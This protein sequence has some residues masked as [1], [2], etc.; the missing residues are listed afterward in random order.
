MICSKDTL[1]IHIYRDLLSFILCIVLAALFSDKD[2]VF[3]I[4]TI[5]DLDLRHLR[6]ASISTT[7]IRVSV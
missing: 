4:I 3:E 2:A 7:Y 5:H 1:I 6:R